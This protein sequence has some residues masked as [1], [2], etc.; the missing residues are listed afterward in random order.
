MKL[1]L[2]RHGIAEERETW[3]GPDGLRPLTP[4]GEKKTSHAVCGLKTIE[5][6]IDIIASSPLLRARQTAEIVGFEYSKKLQIWSELEDA[7]Y[8]A[9]CERFSQ[10]S[11]DATLLCVGHEPGLSQFASQLL[12]GSAQALRIEFKKAGVCTIE[13]ENSDATLLYHLTP[14]QLRGLRF[15]KKQD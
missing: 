3:N 9:M 5:P 15:Q 6:R 14:R 12:T 1:I 8:T 4:E 10:L 2:M 7:N 11:Y 13:I